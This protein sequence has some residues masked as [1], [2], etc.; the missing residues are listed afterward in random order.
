[1]ALIWFSCFCCASENLR[2][3]PSFLA[4]SW[5]DFVLALRQPD[6]APT[7]AKPIVILPSE[8][9]APSSEPQAVSAIALKE[10]AVAAIRVF[11]TTVF[12]P[13]HGLSA[14]VT[15]VTGRECER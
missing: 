5:M 14:P 12:P 3:M 9:E 2:S 7:W 8:A 15:G 11:F 13:D 1:M 6:S 10:I 4:V